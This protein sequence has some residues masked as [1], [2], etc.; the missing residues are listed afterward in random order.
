MQKEPLYEREDVQQ[1][2]E[3]VQVQV[4]E[5]EHTQEVQQVHAAGAR[6]GLTTRAAGAVTVGAHSLGQHQEHGRELQKV[7]EKEKVQARHNG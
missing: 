5:K 4:N 1:E 7:S 2:C 6:A 3:H